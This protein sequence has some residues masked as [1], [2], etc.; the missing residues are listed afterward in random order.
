M[1]YFYKVNTL[2]W[3]YWERKHNTE[4]ARVRECEAAVAQRG[5][6]SKDRNGSKLER[7]NPRQASFQ[8]ASCRVSIPIEEGRKREKT[9]RSNYQGVSCCYPN[10]ERDQAVGHALITWTLQGPTQPTPQTLDLPTP[11]LALWP[12]SSRE[13]KNFPL[14]S[15]RFS[16]L[17]NFENE[18]GFLSLIY[19][20]T[21]VIVAVFSN[22]LELH[23]MNLWT[24]HKFQIMLK[25]DVKL[26]K[27]L[28]AGA[29]RGG[30]ER[31][32]RPG[33]QDP[34]GCRWK[35]WLFHK[36]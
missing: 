26:T 30:G 35:K 14:Y 13:Q 33:A 20:C 22:R 15:C 11:F 18:N 31:E 19:N 23:I 24:F 9:H 6:C 8:H 32:Y 36:T 12:K 27:K 2:N 1:R 29:A 21:K 10:R 7:S 25:Y 3:I 5:G 4:S 17:L 28:H 16:M 34:W